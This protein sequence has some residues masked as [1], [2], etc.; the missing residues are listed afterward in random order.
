M[1]SLVK[2]FYQMANSTTC[3]EKFTY[4][5]YTK[6][7]LARA[8]RQRSYERLCSSFDEE[9][10]INLS[11]L[12]PNNDFELDDWLGKPSYGGVEE[13]PKTIQG[14]PRSVATAR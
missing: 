14:P 6:C 7:F 4:E 9:S 13:R 10:G 3:P 1:K 11:Q 12:D 5:T 8:R 2:H